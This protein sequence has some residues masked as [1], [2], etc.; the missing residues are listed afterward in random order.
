VIIAIVKL[1]WVVVSCFFAWLAFDEVASGGTVK[2]P[3]VATA[4]GL[5]AIA[6]ASVAI[7]AMLAVMALGV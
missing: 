6:K 3:E 7:W 4:S 1:T 2:T 5:R